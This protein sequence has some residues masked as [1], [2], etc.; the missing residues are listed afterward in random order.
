M[1]SWL[2][3]LC[4]SRAAPLADQPLPDQLFAVRP[5]VE[6][7][8][9]C[10]TL[11]DRRLL[12]AGLDLTNT[13]A[14][15]IVVKVGKQKVKDAIT[16]TLV[17]Q[18]DSGYTSGQVSSTHGGT[19]D[20]KGIIRGK[21]LKLVG[22]TSGRLL[23]AKLGKKGLSF[24]GALTNGID[25]S[26]G[27]FKV[28][29]TGDAPASLP[30]AGRAQGSV[31]PTTSIAALQAR[32]LT[33]A[34][35]LAVAPLSTHGGGPLDPGI[36]PTTGNPIDPVTGRPINPGALPPDPT[37]NSPTTPPLP[38]GFPTDGA[39]PPVAAAPGDMIG[40][41]RSILGIFVGQ[42]NGD[43]TGRI[44]NIQTGA[45][46][47]AAV[48]GTR[49][50]VDPRI[51]T[52]TINTQDASGLVTGTLEISEFAT[53][54]AN[55]FTFSGFVTGNAIDL[56]LSGP[57]TGLVSLT[58]NASGDAF[59]GNVFGAEANG[60]R[61]TGPISAVFTAPTPGGGGGGG[62]GQPLPLGEELYHV[63]TTNGAGET[64]IGN[65]DP[66]NS[67]LG[68]DFSV[69]LVPIVINSLGAFDSGA[70]G[71]AGTITIAVY[72]VAN[73]GT[74]VVVADV[75]TA[76]SVLAPNS[77]FRYMTTFTPITLT[78]GIYR[79]AAF[80]FDTTD[81]AADVGLDTYTGAV[82]TAARGSTG[83][84]IVYPA[85]NGLDANNF[86][87]PP[88]GGGPGGAGTL[89]YPTQPAGLPVNRFLAGSFLYAEGAIVDPG[90]PGGGGSPVPPPPPPPPPAVL[91]KPA[92]SAF[93]GGVYNG[94]SGP[95]VFGSQSGNIIPG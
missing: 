72:N 80:G 8:S 20:V 16:V 37:G 55:E 9:I 41:N 66:N 4:V 35:P 44:E 38:P 63:D 11:E 15:S 24:S 21:Q 85:S 65:L 58:L 1:A 12:S 48:Q 26:V 33:P 51:A 60:F 50:G 10:E 74:P 28:K 89:T 2:R 76:N 68:E 22:A 86:F 71:L 93:P 19:V 92:G 91:P 88:G 64:T 95:E 47:G 49:P 46:T 87:S 29:K 13:Y 57:G 62:S 81:L 70:D 14:G 30:A 78:G 73:P 61:A 34:R 77:N 52:F 3:N 40:S 69:G 25:G 31:A 5:R 83:R 56:V 7:H 90:N 45:T 27:K 42:F 23:I 32:P 39:A 53:A 17:S 94:T 59:S 36:D 67:T 75:T 84:E 43:G 6:T 54:P 82:P 18:T 79:I